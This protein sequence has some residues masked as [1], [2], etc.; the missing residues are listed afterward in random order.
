M[1]TFFKAISLVSFAVS[2]SLAGGVAYVYI[3]RDNIIEG[4]KEQVT[5][6]AT[7]AIKGAIPDLLGGDGGLPEVP[8]AGGGLPLPF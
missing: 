3:E 2:V 4:V 8:S 7:D 6:H 5:K 1:N